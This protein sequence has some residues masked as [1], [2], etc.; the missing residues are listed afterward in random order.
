MGKW[1]KRERK[2][3]R[4]KAVRGKKESG[5]GAIKPKCPRERE[6]KWEQDANSLKKSLTL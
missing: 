4:G 3:K 6:N 1:K 2:G 5:R